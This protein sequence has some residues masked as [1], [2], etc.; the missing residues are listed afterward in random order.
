MD[1]RIFASSLIA[2]NQINADRRRPSSGA[3][4]NTHD[5]WCTPT[6][7]DGGVLRIASAIAA[8]WFGFALFGTWLL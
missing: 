1:T 4:E 7:M 3:R 8:V 2:L 6:A 5:E